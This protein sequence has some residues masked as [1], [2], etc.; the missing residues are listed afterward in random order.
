MFFG[1]LKA[2]YGTIQYSVVLT[3]ADIDCAEED[4]SVIR[5]EPDLPDGTEKK[6]CSE[7]E[8]EFIIDRRDDWLAENA[9]L[10]IYSDYLENEKEDW[11]KA[12]AKEH[13][14]ECMN[15]AYDEYFV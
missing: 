2:K 3:P 9:E 11:I 4:E 7:D 14:K 1:A 6:E 8:K 12:Y 5:L 15:I 10:I 13:N